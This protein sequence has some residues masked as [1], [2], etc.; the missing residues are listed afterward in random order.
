MRPSAVWMRNCAGS[1]CVTRWW[2]WFSWPGEAGVAERR[3]PCTLSMRRFTTRRRTG[4]SW[5]ENYWSGG[6][7]RELW[8]KWSAITVL[9]SMLWRI[10]RNGGRGDGGD[11]GDDDDGISPEG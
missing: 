9:S 7:V 4:A 1:W 5:Y 6:R 10:M 3:W 11:S 8:M 2:S